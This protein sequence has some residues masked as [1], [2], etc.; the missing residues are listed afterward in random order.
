VLGGDDDR[1]DTLRGVVAG[2]VPH[3]FFSLAT[4]A[5]GVFPLSERRER[6]LV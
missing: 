5:G 4:R 6:L 3:G 2:H 1:V